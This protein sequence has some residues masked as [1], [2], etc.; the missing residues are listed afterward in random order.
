MENP[1]NLINYIIQQE[2][3]YSLNSRYGYKCKSNRKVVLDKQIA[4]LDKALSLNSGND[5]LLSI[6]WIL[7][8]D[9]YTPEEVPIVFKNNYKTIF[10]L[11]LLLFILFLP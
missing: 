7:A 5:R 9:Y 1:F 4:I 2:T 11:L 8:E 3:L 6:K 10:I